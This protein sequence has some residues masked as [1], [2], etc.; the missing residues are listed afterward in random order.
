VHGVHGHEL[1]AQAPFQK[2]RGIGPLS[3]RRFAVRMSWCRG[4]GRVSWWSGFVSVS[5]WMGD[6]GWETIGCMAGPSS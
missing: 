2:S 1:K 3:R 4:A 6:D 5:W